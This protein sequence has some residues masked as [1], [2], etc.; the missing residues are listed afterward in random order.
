[1]A[2]Q[3]E[4]RQQLED[5]LA[6]AAKALPAVQQGLV[7]GL[8]I[9]AA[10]QLA[11]V[12]ASSAPQVMSR[13][14]QLLPLAQVKCSLIHEGLIIGHCA[15]VVPLETL[16]PKSS[17]S[18]ATLLSPWQPTRPKAGSRGQMQKGS[19]YQLCRLAAPDQVY[20]SYGAWRI[21]LTT[22]LQPCFLWSAAVNVNRLALA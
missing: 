16:A 8:Q 19:L 7:T 21:V 15:I 13:A 22:I 10:P 4:R 1:M 5:L 17:T 2:E 12:H 11:L 14:H 9:S 3:A 18:L 20:Q 6:S